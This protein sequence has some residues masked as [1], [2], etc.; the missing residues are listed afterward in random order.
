MNLES[1]LKS[2]ILVIL[3]TLF[4][5]TAASADPEKFDEILP[6]ASASYVTDSEIINKLN[7]GPGD[8]DPIWCYSTDANAILI[9][10]PSRERDKCELSKR[11]ALELQKIKNQF[12]IDNLKIELETLSEKHIRLIKV[13]DEEIQALT[14]AALKRPNDYS[15][16]WAT[17]GFVTGVA[18]VVS[19]FL[20]VK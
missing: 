5:T 18:T 7:L 1:S 14:A 3:F 20:M 16:W 10:A 4:S 12:Q 8:D 13:K 15:F 9:S 2:K 19:I 6:P 11:Q 17:G